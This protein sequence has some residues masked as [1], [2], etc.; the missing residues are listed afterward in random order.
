MTAHE[1]NQMIT[2]AIYIRD[3]FVPEED[4]KVITDLCNL[5]TNIQD[6][7]A[8]DRPVEES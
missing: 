4:K 2:R 6:I 7:I 5:V 1:I 3:V 8:D